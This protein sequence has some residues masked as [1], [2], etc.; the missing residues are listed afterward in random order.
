M[1][2]LFLLATL[3]ACLPTL[4]DEIDKKYPLGDQLRVLAEDAESPAFH[5]LVME[6]LI[7]DL[8]AE[9]QRVETLDNAESFAETHGGMDKVQT[10]PDLRAAYDR[11]VAI[12]EKFL[13]VMRDGYAH[14]KLQAPFDR[15]AKSEKAGTIK[16]GAATTDVP[17][18][19]ELPSPGSEQ[20]WPRFRG[21]DGQ[22]HSMAHDLPT[23][24]SETENIVWRTPLPGAGNSSPVIWNDRIFLTSAGD[25][26]ADRAL[27]CVA[28]EDG[29]LLWSRTIPVH[30]VEP[31]V[32]DKNGYASATPVTDG[33]RV[34]AFLGAGGLVCY[35]FEGNLV[36]HYPMPDV[37]D[38]TWGTG[39]SPL[40]FENSVIL[41][42]DQNKNDSV[43]LALDKRTGQVLWKRERAKSMGWSTPLVLRVDDRDELVYAGGQTLK[44]YDPRTGEELW[45][46]KGPTVEVIPT[47]VV[48]PHMIFTASG[49]QG[50]TLGV[51]PGGRG[52][53]TDTH[54]AWRA[55]RGG[56]HVPSPIYYDGRLY[57]VN[58]TGIATCLDAESGEMVWQSRIRDKFS[59][60]PIEAQGLL[61]FP[62]ESGVTFVVRPGNKLDIV[63]ENDL[64]SPILASPAAVG[65][66]L[67][68]RTTTELVAI[69]TK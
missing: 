37:F 7:T 59:A 17:I 66:R 19:I 20:Q 35:D 38:T 43:F 39:A 24:W 33:E 47:V 40:L 28:R 45:S 56:P 69:G 31:N 52:D 64:G 15:G 34:I 13:N 63:A 5:K 3:P 1:I 29:R 67:Y 51:H 48:G 10:D 21:P 12:R 30:E 27:H 18:S 62:S 23:R 68:L 32:R 25:K 57:T 14:Y 4:A 44:G 9:W 53:I 58:D 55:V 50:P 65:D 2:L 6:M 42:H 11:R 49:R 26:G 16:R 36:W 22:G 61:Y 8:G 60:S 54:L 41:V 46:L